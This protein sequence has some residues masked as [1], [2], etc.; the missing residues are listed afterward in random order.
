MKRGKKGS[1]SKTFGMISGSAR[2]VLQREY[3][4]HERGLHDGSVFNW[5][6]KLAR[7][8]LR[9]QIALGKTKRGKECRQVDEPVTV[10]IKRTSGKFE[11]TVIRSNIC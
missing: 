2:G 9:V 1:N 8:A 3:S 4:Q 6:P 10:C 5:K 11:Q 7:E